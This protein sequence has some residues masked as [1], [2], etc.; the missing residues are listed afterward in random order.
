MPNL[1]PSLLGHLAAGLLILIGLAGVILP[2]L[3][4]LPLM[5][6]GMLL[7]AWLGDFQ[8]IGALSLGLLAMLTLLG[9]FAD[10]I[11]GV[12]GAKAGGASRQALWGAFWG[13]VFGLFLGIVGL[14]IG[15]LLGAAIGE[16]LARR[17]MLQAGKASVATFIGL[18]LGTVAKVGCALAM[19]L[20]FASA[21]LLG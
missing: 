5:F 1:E 6:A 15:P 19:L 21:L 18:L 2:A 11:A 4:G 7:T 10:F 20:T 14:I 8:H 3:P 9:M 12:L 16:Y 13:S 17:D